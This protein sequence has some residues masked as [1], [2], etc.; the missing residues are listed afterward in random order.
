MKLPP[1]SQEREIY[2]HLADAQRSSGKDQ[3][4][5]PLLDS[6]EDDRE[7]DLAFLVMP[8]LRTFDRPPFDAVSELVELFGQL[9]EVCCLNTGLS[10]GTDSCRSRKGLE[11]MH[12]KNV[13]HWYVR[14]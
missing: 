14:P 8:L 4:I 1:E 13:A 6:F 5:V 3:R 2:Q 10:L 11:F 12:S 7:P 9:L